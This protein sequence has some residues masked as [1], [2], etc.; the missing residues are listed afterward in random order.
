MATIKE[1]LK[2]LADLLKGPE[3]AG[4]TQAQPA[5]KVKAPE[6]YVFVTVHGKRYHWDRL[7]PGLRNAQEV[8]MDISKARKAGYTACDKCCPE[9][10]RRHD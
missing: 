1:W 7:C 10:F 6:P 5:A 9:G 8:K 2:K 3:Q 4:A